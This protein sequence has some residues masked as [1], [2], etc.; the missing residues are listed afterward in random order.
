MIRS[1]AW[2]PIHWCPL[3]WWRRGYQ[4]RP[5]RRAG[6]QIA[7]RSH[8]QALDWQIDA[9][10]PVEFRLYVVAGIARQGNAL[11]ALELAINLLV[12]NDAFF[13]VDD[14]IRSFPAS[15]ST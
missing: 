1:G 12:L 2:P 3:R 13:G 9:K 14:Q 11:D 8:G 5:G 6:I 7:D 10:I 15:M 4:K